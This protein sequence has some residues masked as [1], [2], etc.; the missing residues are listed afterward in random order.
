MSTSEQE[1]LVRDLNTSDEKCPVLVP[2]YKIDAFGYN[3]KPI[4]GILRYWAVRWRSRSRTRRARE[5][6]V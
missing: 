6:I 2:S 5:F 1:Q 3:L 4:V